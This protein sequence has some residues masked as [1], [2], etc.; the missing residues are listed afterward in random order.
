MQTVTDKKHY[1]K[2]MLDECGSMTDKTLGTT[3]RCSNPIQIP[4]YEGWYCDVDDCY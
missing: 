4:G 3:C 1:E 2:P